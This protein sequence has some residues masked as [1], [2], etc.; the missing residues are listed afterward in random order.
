MR[1]N[2]IK[3]RAKRNSKKVKIKVALI[4]WWHKLRNLIQVL[5]QIGDVAD[6]KNEPFGITEH[7]INLKAENMNL[8][9]ILLKK[10]HPTYCKY[11]VIT[12][13]FN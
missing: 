7:L 2:S 6:F 11:A 13:A 10:R 12:S 5:L 8:L 1:K 3:D 4:M 9:K